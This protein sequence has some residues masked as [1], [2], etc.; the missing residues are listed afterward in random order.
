[1]AGDFYTSAGV[2]MPS[3]S[4]QSSLCLLATAGAGRLRGS[5]YTRNP[6]PKFSVSFMI[7][8]TP[9]RAV[10]A[11]SAALTTALTPLAAP[12]QTKYEY[13][14][15]IPRLSAT[16]AGEAAPTQPAA[17]LKSFSLSSSSASL[18]TYP[19]LQALTMFSVTNTSTEAIAPTVA[20]SGSFASKFSLS[21]CDGAALAPGESCAVQVRFAPGSG[22]ANP[23]QDATVTVAAAG[24][25]SKTFSLMGSSAYPPAY[26]TYA[27]GTLL[28]TISGNTVTWPGTAGYG[29]FT[30][31]A[32]MRAAGQFAVAYEGSPASLNALEFNVQDTG[33]GFY[34]VAM[35]T[36]KVVS[37][38]GT[39]LFSGS[40]AAGT[41]VPVPTFQTG[42]RV[43]MTANFSSRTVSWYRC[44]ASACTEPAFH[45][46]TFGGTGAMRIYNWKPNTA[47]VS[48]NV[49]TTGIVGLPAAA[50]SHHAGL[51]H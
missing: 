14:R 24:A 3:N 25:D 48:L 36:K 7:K 17:P 40:S 45:T 15:A 43:V 26:P 31:G 51:P 35:P 39:A 21:G 47:A 44:S 29:G 23:S 28:P 13:R 6:S 5:F 2:A 32:T 9:L 12:A 22:A 16:P 33:G 1:M 34:G 38:A 49:V 10:L 46:S 30:V 20:L 41:S 4:C 50:A 37:A 8:T 19:T 11:L 18:A 27:S 42:D